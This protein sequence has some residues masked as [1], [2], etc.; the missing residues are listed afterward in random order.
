M[1]D[2]LIREVEAAHPAMIVFVASR[3]S[4]A[5]RPGSDRRVLDWADRYLKQCY[6]VVGVTERLPDGSSES[7]W[8]AEA[9]G[10]QPRSGNVVYTLKRRSNTLCSVE[11]SSPP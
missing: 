2:E 3:T 11:T 1:Q 9:A 10:H 7:H 4:W 6:D 8:D 5:P